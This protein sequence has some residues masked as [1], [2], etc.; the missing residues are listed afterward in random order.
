MGEPLVSIKIFTEVIRELSPQTFSRFVE[1]EP[2]DDSKT[3]LTIAH[4]IG[5][6]LNL[7]HALPAKDQNGTFI[8]RNIPVQ[9]VMGDQWSDYFV[10]NPIDQIVVGTDVCRWENLPSS[11]VSAELASFVLK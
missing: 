10:D 9:T 5:D 3:R 1:G 7:E 2:Y 8:C 4:E 11:Y 6:G